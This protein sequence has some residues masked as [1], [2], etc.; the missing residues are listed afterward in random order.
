MGYS[1]DPV[2]HL[3]KGFL[4][5]KFTAFAAEKLLDAALPKP[6]DTEAPVI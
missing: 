1:M 2:D 5:P 4:L 3:I 6:K